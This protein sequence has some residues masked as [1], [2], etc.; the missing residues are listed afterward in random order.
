MS[1]DN[2]DLRENG[3]WPF[4][5]ARSPTASRPTTGRRPSSTARSCGTSAAGPAARCSTGSASTTR[6][7]SSP[8]MPDRACRGCTDEFGR[9]FRS[10]DYG[11]GAYR[12]CVHFPLA[13]FGSV[14]GDRTEL[15]LAHGG[16]VGLQR[17]PGPGPPRGRP[18]H[19]RRRLRALPHLQGAPRHGAGLR[20]PRRE[21]RDRPLLPGQALRPGLRLRRPHLRGRA[22]PGRHLLHRRGHGRPDRPDDLGPPHPRVPAAGDEADD[23]P[24]P[25]GRRPRLPPQRRQLLA[26][27]PRHD[28]ARHRPPQPPP[29]ALPGH[30]ARAAEEGVRPAPRPP[31]RHGQPVHAAL[32][33]GRRGPAGG[34]GQPADP[35][36]G[37]RLHPGALPQHPGVDARSRTSWRCTTPPASSGVHRISSNRPCPASF[38]PRNRRKKIYRRIRR[39]P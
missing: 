6:S 8:A 18:S 7:S 35:G 21:P 4:S 2:D 19:P 9:R 23:R 27:H 32:R 38:G 26:H 10:V 39:R 28:R 15:R 30:G 36:R 16:L 14:A 33:D 1:R 17:H 3:G 12:E 34:R 5:P 22:R 25:P 24:G 11:T 31:R 29:M 13:G 20:R 37:R